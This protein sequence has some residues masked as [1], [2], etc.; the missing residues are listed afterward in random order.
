[1]ST[2]PVASLPDLPPLPVFS[3]V[4]RRPIANITEH[5]CTVDVVVLQILLHAA[6][7]IMNPLSYFMLF[8]TIVVAFW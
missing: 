4:K 2:R 3:R 8:E 1:M 7:V 6:G 5:H